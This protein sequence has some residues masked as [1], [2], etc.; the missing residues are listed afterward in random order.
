MPSVFQVP[1]IKEDNNALTPTNSFYSYNKMPQKSNLGAQWASSNSNSPDAPRII[2]SK[3]QEDLIKQKNMQFSP[4][5]VD[6]DPV[7]IFLSFF[8]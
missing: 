6:V 4:L 2:F 1:T 8:L 3:I 5:T 7:T